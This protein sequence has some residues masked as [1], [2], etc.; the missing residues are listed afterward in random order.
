MNHNSSPFSC[1][2]PAVILLFYIADSKILKVGSEL[3]TLSKSQ[4]D[5]AGRISN[6]KAVGA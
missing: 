3:T 1:D 5:T 6:Q 2:Y 4:G